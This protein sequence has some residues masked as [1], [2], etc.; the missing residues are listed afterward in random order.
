MTHMYYKKKLKAEESK[1]KNTT[2]RKTKKY[3]KVSFVTI[4]I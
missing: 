4:I 3:Y 2:V 1:R